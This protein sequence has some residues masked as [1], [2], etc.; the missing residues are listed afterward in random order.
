MIHKNIFLLLGSNVGD[1]PG[2]LSMAIDLI[3]KEIGKTIVMSKIYETAP[4]GKADQ[5]HF[6]NRAI[7]I[8]SQFSP[9]ELLN[10][11]K[12]IEQTLGRTRLEKWGERSIDI[13]IIYFEDKII[14]SSHLVIPHP[15]I[16][17]RRFV[18]TPLVEI[19]PEFV[20]PLLKKSNTELLMECKDTLDVTAFTS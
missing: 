4:W 2:Q 12:S 15:H 5:P 14:D 7:E 17:E 11:V 1:R 6:L 13:D 3:E 9:H 10:K 20:H 8:E 16:A 19:S 18:L